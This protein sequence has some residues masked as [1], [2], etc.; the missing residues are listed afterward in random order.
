[1]A[2]S[3]Q[4]L[5][6]SIRKAHGIAERHFR[7]GL[8]PI[9]SN[10]KERL[11][12]V[13]TSKNPSQIQVVITGT[14]RSGTGY[15]QSLLGS[16]PDSFVKG[17]VFDPVKHRYQQYVQKAQELAHKRTQRLFA[18]KF[19][20][21]QAPNYSS[22]FAELANKGWKFVGTYRENTKAQALSYYLA[23][24]I[25]TFHSSGS[26]TTPKPIDVRSD[27]LVQVQHLFEE[28]QSQLMRDYET[29]G[30]SLQ[31]IHFE[32]DIQTSK[33]GIYLVAQHLGLHAEGLK[34]KERPTFS[35]PWQLIRN[36]EEIQAL[37]D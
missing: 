21:F 19:L 8:E 13:L 35:N 14:P 24:A 18:L 37:M 30:E 7:K 26:T 28:A 29:L 2:I 33:Q 36:T 32:Q 5:A 31:T 9:Y 6:N 11:K 15:I 20:L 34:E 25:D 4:N 10:T 17:E 12:A 16:Y 1:M 23:T 27:L 3:F 22:D